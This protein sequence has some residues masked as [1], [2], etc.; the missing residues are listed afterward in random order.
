MNRRAVLKAAATACAA[1]AGGSLAAG[2]SEAAADTGAGPDGHGPAVVVVVSIHVKA[3]REQ[4]FLRLVTPVLDAMRHEATFINAALH[5]DPEDPTRFM[6][7]ETWADR[8]DLVEVQM[9]RDYRGAYEARLPAIL[10]E[11]RRAEVWRPLRGDFTFFA[12]ARG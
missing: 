7:Y 5:R 1:M 9:K 6:L 4:E 3:G 10:R 2:R 8:D 11:P 12:P